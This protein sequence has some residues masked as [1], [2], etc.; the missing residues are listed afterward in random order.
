MSYNI[1]DPRIFYCVAN[2]QGQLEIYTPDG[3][4]LYGITWVRAQCK[5]NEANRVTLQMIVKILPS[6]ADMNEDIYQSKMKGKLPL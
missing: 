6:E 5:V 1:D 4:L 3:K 2:K